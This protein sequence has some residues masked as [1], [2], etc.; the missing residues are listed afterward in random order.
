[1]IESILIKEN[2]SFKQVK[3]DI[4]PGLSVFT[5]LS[6]AGKSVLFNAILSAFALSE[7]EAKMVEILLD[8][9][10]RLEEYGIENEELNVFKY[11]KDKNTRYF[12]NNQLVSKK[13]LSLLSKQF[14]KYLSA[15]ENNEFSNERMI[16]LLD[17]MCE[18]K[19][20]NFGILKQE[21]KNLFKIYLEY[22]NKLEQIKDEEKKVEELKEFTKFEIDKIQSINPKIGEFEELMSLKKKLSKKD[23]IDAAWVKASAIFELESAVIDALQI[24]EVDSLFFSECLNELRVIWESQNLDDFDF[25][26]EEVL[27][28]I[29][30]LSS[31]ISKYGS[32]EETL[33]ILEKKQKDLN[34]YENLSFEKEE[35]EQKVKKVKKELEEKSNKISLLRQGKITKLEQLLNSYLL[36]LYM[37]DIKLQI[38]ECH[39]GNLGKD[40]IVLNIN[41]AKLKNLSSG[42]LNRL[43]LAFIATE[44]NITSDGKGII[45]LDEIDANLSGKEAMSIADILKEL[46]NFYQIFAI[47]HLPQLS[48]KANNHFL[49][50]KHGNESVVRKIENEERI[51]ELARM[52]SG[53]N[54]TQEAVEFARTLL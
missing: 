5:G 33:E 54:I 23:K 34:H 2:L 48:S 7:S 40:E 43:R 44:C 49:V 14:V 6:G 47:S 51:K 29:E 13:N 3:I 28:R 12:V 41:E 46:S 39:L 25:D 42:E 35:L 21:F 17:C 30:K 8:D 20:S 18:K 36:K 27:D 53:E 26:I 31:L 1:M 50:E 22:N 16:N 45:F 38:K 4:Q 11:L 19:D 15:K 9:V 52:V 32:I 24:S 37:K 10:L